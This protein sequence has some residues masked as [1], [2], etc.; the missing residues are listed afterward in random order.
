VSLDLATSKLAV[1]GC[2]PLD[3]T[4]DP[5]QRVGVGQAKGLVAHTHV[6]V[7]ADNDNLTLKLKGGTYLRRQAA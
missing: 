7:I 6:N 2:M 4:N 3:F 5:Q 1:S